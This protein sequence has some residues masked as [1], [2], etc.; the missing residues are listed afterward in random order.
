MK[1][2]SKNILFV[3]SLTA[4]AL[5]S[6]FTLKGYIKEENK[7]TIWLYVTYPDKKID[8]Y[9]EV[10]IDGSVLMREKNAKSVV[11]REGTIKKMYAKD[12]FRET[13]N[14]DI[15]AYSKNIDISKMLFFKGELVKISANIKGEIIR[16]VSP[17][18]MFSN[19]FIYAFRQVYDEAIKLPE[20]KKYVSFI[21]A[22]PMNTD[23]YNDFL[24]K[25]PA[26]YEIPVVETKELKLNKYIFRAVNYPWRLIPIPSDDEENTIS[27]FM[28]SYNL[29]GLKSSFYLGTTRGKF[30]LSIVEN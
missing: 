29:Y 1:F 17:L 13:K 2:I 3:L 18:N 27:D 24:K 10:S 9:L 21:Y 30:Q 20:T 26:N 16:V 25:V 15:M 8:Y 5:L 19:T 7:D 22:A 6:S 23:L 11:V 4:I 28:S 12:F 14:S